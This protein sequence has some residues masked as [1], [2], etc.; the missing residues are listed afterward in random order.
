M[1]AC[2]YDIQNRE[3]MQFVCKSID[4]KQTI[5]AW[6]LRTLPVKWKLQFKARDVG[7]FS[8]KNSWLWLSYSRLNTYKFLN[9][10]AKRTNEAKPKTFY[11][12][13][14]DIENQKYSTWI[15][16]YFKLLYNFIKWFIYTVNFTE[17]SI[18]KFKTGF[19]KAKFCYQA[20]FI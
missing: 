10:E 12:C 1:C 14:T 3:K 7:E 17:T 2:W 15:N 8:I 16:K 4:Q 18:T 6:H 11:L 20:V 19:S 13:L 5:D 9:M